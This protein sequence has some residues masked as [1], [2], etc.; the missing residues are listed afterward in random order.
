MANFT[1]N[2]ISGNQI[3]QIKNIPFGITYCEGRKSDKIHNIFKKEFWWC[4]NQECFENC[5][6]NHLTIK[7]S[8]NNEENPWEK[9]TLFDFIKILN[10]DCDEHNGNYT[11]KDGD[12]YKFLGHINAFNRLLERLYCDECHYLLYPIKTSNFALYTDVNFH[13]I[14]DNCQQKSKEIYLT[15]CLNGECKA[16]IDSRI[17][18]L[19]EY[20]FYIC[21]NCGTCCS[22]EVFKRRHE[23]LKKLAG[24]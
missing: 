20:G 21:C 15:R 6:T 10:I 1:R 12:Y 2:V 13:C 8:H 7:C 23:S 9:L 24:I 3:I 4:C 18:K 5:V 17:S 19:C 11:I 16:I 22:E 14:Q